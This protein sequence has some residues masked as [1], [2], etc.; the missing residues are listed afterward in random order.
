MAKKKKIAPIKTIYYSDELNDECSE[1]KI[2]PR[3]I[4]EKYVYCHD[5]VF[6]KF[7]SFFWY[8]IVGVPCAFLCFGNWIAARGVNDVAGAR[9]KGPPLAAGRWN[10]VR[11][12]FDQKTA[13]I[14]TN[15]V[16]GE[17][18]E[19]CGMASNSDCMALGMLIRTLDFFHGR[20][21]GLSIEP[22]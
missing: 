20:I 11:L 3:P 22:R 16:L 2:T 10:T 5:S 15:G 14:E 17:P 21:S 13:R 19:A 9:V 18:A 6:K 4:D 7:T 12:V 8:R 1:A